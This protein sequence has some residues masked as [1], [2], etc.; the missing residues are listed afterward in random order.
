MSSIQPFTAEYSL[1]MSGEIGTETGFC[2]VVIAGPGLEVTPRDGVSIPVRFAEITLWKAEDYSFSMTLA[3]STELVIMKLARRFDEFTNNFRNFRRE[4]FLQALLL[5]EE[6]SSAIEGGHY[7]QRNTSG[8]LL[9]SGPCSVH[10]QRTS[11]ACFPDVRLP[12]LISYGAMTA[13]NRDPEN[14][15]VSIPCDDGEHLLLN[16]FAK[17]T[18]ELMAGLNHKYAELARRQSAA[19][20][21][22]APGLGAMELRRGAALLR[23]GVPAGREQ[24]QAGAPGVWESLW[25]SGFCEDRRSYAEWLLGTSSRAFV[26]IKETGPWGAGEG[27]PAAL[28]DRRLLYLFRVGDAMVL[29]APSTDDAATYIFRITGDADIFARNL[30]RACAA[31]QFRR[32]PMYLPLAALNTPPYD[33]YAE[34]ARILPALVALRRAFIGRAIHH[35]LSSWQKEIGDLLRSV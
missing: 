3:G 8:E 31:V 24:L 9:A 26:V 32:E 10:L 34:A 25:Q 15:G 2:S 23:D 29:E 14:Y 13:M 35:S 22:L 16:R 30:C 1:R 21:A 19:I 28:A 17:R 4:Y 33:R 20:A 7:E 18:D 27:T 11:L 6:K 12:F 5:E